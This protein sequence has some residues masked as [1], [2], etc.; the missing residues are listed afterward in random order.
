MGKM[1]RW[2]PCPDLLRSDFKRDF[3][4]KHT[5]VVRPA[6]GD[7]LALRIDAYGDDGGRT[8]W[9]TLDSSIQFMAMLFCSWLGSFMRLTTF[10]HNIWPDRSKRRANG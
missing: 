10:L 4:S 2:K 3:A 5:T 8:L 6:H 9:Q 1:D 7:N